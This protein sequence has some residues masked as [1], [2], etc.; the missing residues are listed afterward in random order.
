M[1]QAAAKYMGVETAAQRAARAQLENASVVEN[2][3]RSYTS[4]RTQLDPVFAA[5]KQ[6]ENAQKQ[7]NAAVKAGVITQTEANRVLGLAE[8]KY[9][10]LTPVAQKT[11]MAVDDLGR[12]SGF[13]A[14][15]GIRSLGLQLNQVAQVGGMT[16]NWM[17]ALAIQLPDILLSFG[18]LGVFAGI[19]AGAMIP[20]ISTM[21]ASKSSTELSA[22]ATKNYSEALSQIST[23]MS[24]AK[25]LEAEY[26][27]AVI[28]G[29]SQRVAALQA[30]AQVR[31]ALLQLDQNDLAADQAAAQ[32]K[33][34]AV[35]AELTATLESQAAQL[36]VM[37]QVRD[38]L[39]KGFLEPTT[40]KNALE[41]MQVGL[42]QIN[43]KLLTQRENA[44]RLGLE[45]DLV[46]KQID[47]NKFALDAVKAMLLRIVNGVPPIAVALNNAASEAYGLSTALGQAY[48]YAAGLRS[49]IDGMN[50]SNIATAA[51]NAALL[52]GSTVAA[53]TA[54]GQLAEQ[55]AKLAPMLGSED[56]IIRK[57]AASQLQAYDAALQTNVALNEQ[58]AALV[59]TA[60][61]AS[62]AGKATKAAMTEAEK[63]TK[64]AAKAAEDAAKSYVET[65]QGFVSS[66]IGSF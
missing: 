1:E 23:D 15:G 48:G 26:A 5:S 4:L 9:L 43:A 42:E 36:A 58:H 54:T 60:T 45:Y 47:S 18:T 50:F 38:E 66:G 46:S 31:A 19:A 3:S 62:G 11:A 17:S 16:G 56:A 49:A 39:A 30:E 64:K 25:S 40:A 65:M 13:A 34:A 20:L 59:K 44:K 61:A 28:S 12:K 33:L 22:E 27:A 37:A 7:L 63:A 57:Q 52:A 6:Y 24:S 8:S 21:V 51:S 14:S 35:Q 53:A 55:R 10:G 2:A 41:N 32:A 29:S